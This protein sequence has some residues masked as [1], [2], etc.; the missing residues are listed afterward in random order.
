MLTLSL[1]LL[2]LIAGPLLYH[3]LRRGGWV[4]KT[5]DGAIAAALALVLFLDLVPETIS[6][7][8]IWALFWIGAGYLL[9]SGLERLAHRSASTMHR[10]A[11]VLAAA[12]LGLHAALE[13]AGLALGKLTAGTG[14]A[15]AIILHRMIVGLVVWFMLQPAFGRK[16]ATAALLAIGMATLLGYFAVQSIGFFETSSVAWYGQALIIGLVLHGLIHRTH[17]HR[18]AQ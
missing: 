6:Q 10:F 16:V 14:L 2:A 1:S 15:A 18:H 12:G 5:L 3:R 11:L 17:V 7:T 9:P 8:G 4:A 13:G